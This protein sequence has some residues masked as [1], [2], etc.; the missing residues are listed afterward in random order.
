MKHSVISKQHVDSHNLIVNIKLIPE[1][2]FEL[3]AINNLND[4]QA[5]SDEK[6]LIENYLHFNLALGNYSIVKLINQ[7]KN[8]F[9]IQVFI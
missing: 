5:S 3:T 2:E 8:N 6:E 7:D 9:T 4:T 1:T